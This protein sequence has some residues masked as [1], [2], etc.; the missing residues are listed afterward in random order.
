MLDTTL[1][2]D[3]SLEKMPEFENL[4]KV[5]LS[6]IQADDIRER[7]LKREQL[8]LQLIAGYLSASSY[9]AKAPEDWHRF[10]SFVIGPNKLS[11]ADLRH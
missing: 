2:Q 7:E 4:L 8:R 11:K 1:I 10:T 3:N 5:E 6:L 9:L